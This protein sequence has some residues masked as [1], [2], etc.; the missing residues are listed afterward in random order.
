MKACPVR[1]L[2]K[3]LKHPLNP[4][5]ILTRNKYLTLLINMPCSEHG[6]VQSPVRESS[7]T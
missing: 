7:H 2:C 3:N 4:R 5:Q 1:I 6:Y